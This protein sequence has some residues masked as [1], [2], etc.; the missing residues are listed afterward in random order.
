M[1]SRAWSDADGG[2]VLWLDTN[3]PLPPTVQLE[4]SS[5]V[6]SERIGQHVSLSLPE[7]TP[8]KRCDLGTLQLS[9][10]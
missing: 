5:S 7:L 2:I 1:L 4:V 8:G 6:A 9:R 10:P 3:H